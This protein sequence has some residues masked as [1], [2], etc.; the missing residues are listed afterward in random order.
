MAPARVH[1]VPQ[2]ERRR[3]RHR[4]RDGDSVPPG[5]LPEAQT[6]RRSRPQ[7]RGAE[8]PQR[9]RLAPTLGTSWGGWGQFVLVS[10]DSGGQDAGHRGTERFWGTGFLPF[11]RP[12]PARRPT[13]L[14]LPCPCPRGTL[15]VHLA[16]VFAYAPVSWLEGEGVLS[17]P[18]GIRC[19]HWSAASVQV[20]SSDVYRKQ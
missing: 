13:R 12:P 19:L 1:S 20:C 11:T 6:T 10:G 5:G 9:E 4:A 8:S 16:R 15:G 3:V 14:P 2:G 18:V 7:R 17:V